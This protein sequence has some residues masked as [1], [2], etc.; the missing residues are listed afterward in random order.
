MAVSQAMRTRASAISS[1]VAG[2]GRRAAGERR[3]LSRP[4]GQG[5]EASTGQG[6]EASLERRRKPAQIRMAETFAPPHRR[7]SAARDSFAA[8]LCNTPEK[9]LH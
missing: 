3:R 2:A 1:R 5:C 9:P 7:P 4:T 6:C 8:R